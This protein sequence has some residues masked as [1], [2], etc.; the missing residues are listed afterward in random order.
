M[1]L[2]NRKLA[3]TRKG[4]LSKKVAAP[5]PREAS[6]VTNARLEKWESGCKT[7]KR[8]RECMNRGI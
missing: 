8:K 4:C 7:R 2:K 1:C 6:V 3:K 5:V